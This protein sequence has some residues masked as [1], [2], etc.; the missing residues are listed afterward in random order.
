MNHANYPFAALVGQD[1]L[2]LALL[3][4][5][6]D[7]VIGGVLISGEKG[8]AKSTAARA[9]AAV[10]PAI[11][12][13]AGCPFQCGDPGSRDRWDECPHCGSLPESSMIETPVPFIDLPLGATE[14]RVLGT[15]D[16]QRA[17]RDGQ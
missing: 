6:V 8:T 3:L 14:D 13:V 17:L 12:R 4:N 11:R 9:L 15:L 5:A 10:L 2:K 1:T 7:P 16:I